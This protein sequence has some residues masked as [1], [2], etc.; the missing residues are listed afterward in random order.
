MTIKNPRIKC[1]ICKKYRFPTKDH[2]PPQSCG[3]S[4]KRLKLYF[5]SSKIGKEV[6]KESQKGV[7]YDYI[8]SDCNNRILGADLDLEF[9][10]FYDFAEKEKGNAIIWSGDIAK[11]IKCIFGHILATNKYSSSAY[12]I[13]MRNFI[14]KNT[15]PKTITLYLFYYPYDAIFAIKHALPVVFSHDKLRNYECPENTMVDC[16][17]FPPFAFIVSDPGK[18]SQGIDLF[19]LLDKNENTI[20][21]SKDSWMDK[22]NN[23]SLPPCWPCMV[24]GGK[25]DNTVDAIIAAGVID[26]VNISVKK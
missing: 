9:K 22:A 26:E 1:P 19:D 18:F 16:L 13:Q 10:K 8:C 3:N 21:L 17:Y 23:K 2:V 6:I 20:E 11:I 24:S 5:Y 14:W 12:D 15:L 7:Y 25:E 4:G